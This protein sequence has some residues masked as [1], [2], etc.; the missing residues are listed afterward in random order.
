[1]YL[2]FGF[3]RTTQD[4]GIDVRRGAMSRSQAVQLVKLYDDIYPD[5]LFEE[6][7]EYYKMSMKEFQA[8]IDNGLT[9]IFLKKKTGGYLNLRL[10]NMKRDNINIGII[11]CE[12]GNIASLINAVNFLKF[13]NE[14]LIEPKK[15]LKIS[16]I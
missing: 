15:I 4:A 3:G 5:K 9:K 12:F 14:I 1:M 8:N 6:Y 7:C 11:N 13:S 16:L 2:K 10:N